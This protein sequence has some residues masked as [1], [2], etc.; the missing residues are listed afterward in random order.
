VL[1]LDALQGVDD[2]ADLHCRRSATSIASMTCSIWGAVSKGS[3]WQ[4]LDPLGPPLVQ[5]PLARSV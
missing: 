5:A 3:N 4:V 2:L 1:L